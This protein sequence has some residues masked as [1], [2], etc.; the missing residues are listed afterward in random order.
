MTPLLIAHRGDSAHAPENT[1][2]AFEQAIRKG[3]DWI[4]MDLTLARDGEVV[5]SHDFSLWRRARSR[6]RLG[7]LSA[8]ELAQVDVSRGFPGFSPTGVP[9]LP[10]VLA[11]IGSRLPLYLELKSEGGGR[12]LAAHRQL[13]QRC[14]QL[15]P[16]SS[17]HALASFDTGLVRGALQAK[18]RAILILSDP[19][20]LA[21]LRTNER[22]ALYAVSIRHDLLGEPFVL[23]LREE[24]L[25]IWAWTLDAERD[26]A[27]ARK[28]GA[29]GICGNDVAQLRA[30]LDRQG[31]DS[32]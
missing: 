29:E 30:T 24:G 23:R 27:R 18:R 14:L 11:V 19:A 25:R 22:R 12:R 13:L 6:R 9:R 4:E 5:V 28:L 20:A 17:P 31:E 1:L 26:I 7:D 32:R 16:A 3:A 8:G 21:R 10:E 15:V 2:P